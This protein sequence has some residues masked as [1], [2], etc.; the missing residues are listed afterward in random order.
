M[1]KMIC[2]K[3]KFISIRGKSFVHTG[4]YRLLEEKTGLDLGIKAKATFKKMTG[5]SASGWLS[6]RPESYKYHSYLIRLGGVPS[7][8]NHESIMSA[9]HIIFL[10]LRAGDINS[11]I[12]P[13]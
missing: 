7:Q 13:V 4:S 3:V 5:I 8:L 11:I 2:D 6:N 12:I 10:L 9:K 1:K